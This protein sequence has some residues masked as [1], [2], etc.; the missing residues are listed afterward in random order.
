MTSTHEQYYCLLKQAVFSQDPEHALAGSSN[1]GRRLFRQEVP[2]EEVT[3]IHHTALLR[4]AAEHPGMAL[5]RVAA[6]LSAPLMEVTMAY[7][8]AFR[9]QVEH[10]YSALMQARLAQSSKLE[11]L[12]TLAAGIAHDFNTL[13]GVI[14]GY[15][16][17]AGDAL[18]EGSDGRQCLE[19]IVSATFRARDLIA[20]MLAF[21]RQQ[22]ALPVP[23]DP[24]AVIDDAL[25]M[26]SVSLDPRIVLTFE[27]DANDA[28]GTTMLADPTQ[29]Q[30][31]VIN[32][33][34][35]AVDAMAGHGR[36]RVTLGR[37]V[38]P[39]AG[40]PCLHLAV[41]DTGQGMPPEVRE[42]IFDPFFTTKEP[43][44]G[45]GLGLA[46]V[47]GIVSTLQ[48]EI[49]VSTVV[50]AGSRFDVWLP[51]APAAHGEAP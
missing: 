21:A 3:D 14:N 50:G 30:Q 48:G 20:R 10:K 16:E 46:I 12:G 43:G 37:A 15:A 22:P 41:A 18:A 44:Q 26:L 4:L 31:I 1:L 23:I 29:L 47:Y 35:N 34:V 49:E 38:R 19:H 45:S 6:R 8:M 25:Q 9:Q 27:A 5:E 2:P 7:S 42:R 17:L 13:L 32:L 33:C 36:L 40:A 51:L 24:V 28:N 11:S 39:G